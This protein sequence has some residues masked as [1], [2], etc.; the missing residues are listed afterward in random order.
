MVFH[1][2]ISF[3][4]I[5]TVS[6]IISLHQVQYHIFL[7]PALVF[8]SPQTNKKVHQL[9]ARSCLS[10]YLI[11]TQYIHH[12]PPM[13]LRFYFSDRNLSRDLRIHEAAVEGW[14]N[15]SWLLQCPK[16]RRQGG[17]SRWRWCMVG[18][19]VGW[20]VGTGWA[21]NAP[22]PFFFKGVRSYNPR[23]THL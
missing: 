3:F 9:K 16:L 22:L 1:H 2:R 7:L 6:A 19:L 13:V 14:L 5:H 20:L 21:K 23:K 12:Y 8:T 4:N 18:W 15:T 10:R 11:Y 17:K